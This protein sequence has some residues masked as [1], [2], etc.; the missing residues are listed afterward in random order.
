MTINRGLSDEALVVFG[1]DT[2]G[3][4]YYATDPPVEI[5]PLPPESKLRTMAYRVIVS[6]PDFPVFKS[7]VYALLPG[8][9]NSFHFGKSEPV[10]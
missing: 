2:T 5:E 10:K 8:N 3:K 4:A 6:G 9:W 1:I 7:P